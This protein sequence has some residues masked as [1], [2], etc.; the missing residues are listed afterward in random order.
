[1]LMQAEGLYKELVLS[2]CYEFV[3]QCCASIAENLKE[4]HKQRYIISF[5][6]LHLLS[7]W[8]SDKFTSFLISTIVTRF[9][10]QF[11]SIN[12]RNIFISSNQLT[13]FSFHPHILNMSII[14][15]CL[16]PNKK[17]NEANLCSNNEFWC[18]LC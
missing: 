6:L 14:L 1:M 13:Y 7:F 11:L 15:F 3:G 8:P 16:K 12:L 9:L 17:I 4:M 5:R 18:L 2:S 10:I